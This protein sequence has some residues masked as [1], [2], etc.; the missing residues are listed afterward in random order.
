MDTVDLNLTRGG[1]IMEIDILGIDLAKRVFQL[2]GADHRGRAVHRAKVSRGSLLEAVRTLKPRVV[3]MEACSTAH[4]WARRLQSLGIEVRLI[5][6]QY[7]SPSRRTRTTATMRKRS[8]RPPAGPPCASLQS[9][10]SSNRT[11]RPHT[12]CAQFYS[13]TVPP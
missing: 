13:A 10:R 2:H 8:S 11:S 4:H 5:S 12:A 7:V 3:V 6:P 9:S 1:F